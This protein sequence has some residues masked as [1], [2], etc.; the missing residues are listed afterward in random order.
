MITQREVVPVRGDFRMQVYRGEQLVLEYQDR[1]LI[2]D[3]ARS[4]M[5]RL[6]SGEVSGRSIDRIAFGTNQSTPTPGD[7]GI[8]SAYMKPVQ[9]FSYPAPGQVEIAWNLLVTEANGMSIG[10]F[11]L[12]TADG[13]LFARKHRTKAIEKESDISIEGQWLIIF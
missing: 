6:I 10:E 5:A 4:V 2:V 1:N 11:G 8:T 3:A 7:T 9:A 13:A 12:L